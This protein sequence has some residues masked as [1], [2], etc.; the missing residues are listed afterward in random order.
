MTPELDAKLC[1]SYPKMFAD[2]YGDMTTT[3][4]CW[5]F[6]HSDGWYNIIDQLCSHI[7]H[8]IDWKNEQRERAIKYNEM[9]TEAG[10]GN[11]EPLQEYYKGYRDIDEKIEEALAKGLRPVP[12]TIPQVVVT[13]V[14]E[15]FGTLR[16]YY[17]GGDDII[18]GMVRMAEGMSG[19]T[20]EECGKPGGRRGGGW[21]VTLCDEHAEARGIF[22]EEKF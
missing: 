8:H 11:R 6:E 21:I 20:C 19:C 17:N 3:A 5:G 22:T 18:D 7:Q 15:K 13:Q 10:Y 9:I 16:F 4:M 12:D 1:S 2:R 14:K